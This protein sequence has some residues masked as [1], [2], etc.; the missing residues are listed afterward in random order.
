M[1]N[2]RKTT[3]VVEW[4]LIFHE[5]LLI[6]N[7]LRQMTKDKS[8]DHSESADIHHDLIGRKA[9]LLNNNVARLLDFVS[10]RGNPLSF[11]CLE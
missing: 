5:I 7:N 1:G 3:V 8:M 2:T 10:S 6:S 4:Q 11:L 9:D